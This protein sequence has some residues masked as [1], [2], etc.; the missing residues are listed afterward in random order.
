MADYS[1]GVAR[2]RIVID[3]TGAIAGAEAAAAASGS[4]RRQNLILASSLGVVGRSM[5]VMGIA[6]LAGFGVAVALAALHF[7]QVSDSARRSVRID[8]LPLCPDATRREA[9]SPVRRCRCV[10][11]SC[12]RCLVAATIRSSAN[13]C[14]T[15]PRRA[16]RKAIS[17]GALP[18]I[19]TS[20]PD[21]LPIA[22]T[23]TSGSIFAPTCSMVD[24]AVVDAVT[25][26]T[27]SK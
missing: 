23:T 22:A 2:G 10:Q 3:P 15:Y 4:M 6:A 18:A 14:T 19:E 25:V 17:S 24:A 9:V 11:W 16:S 5:T 8:G 13:P 1:L 21:A 7:G 20:P 12:A 26:S 27:A